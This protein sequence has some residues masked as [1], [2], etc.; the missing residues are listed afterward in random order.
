M[1]QEVV[2]KHRGFRAWDCIA[3]EDSHRVPAARESKF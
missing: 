2:M 1:V 3:Q